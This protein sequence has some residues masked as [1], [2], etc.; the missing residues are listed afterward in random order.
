MARIVYQDGGVSSSI[1]TVPQFSIL[2]LLV[3][4]GIFQLF[5]TANYAY[6][7]VIRGV[8]MRAA[9]IMEREAYC[10]RMKKEYNYEC[11]PLK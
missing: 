6:E 4:L 5:Q 9:I 8:A 10:A 7:L 3:A 11:P 1:G 2:L